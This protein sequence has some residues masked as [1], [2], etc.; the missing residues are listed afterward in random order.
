MDCTCF[1]WLKRRS[2]R[3]VSAL[4][5]TN[6]QTTLSLETEPRFDH[7]LPNAPVSRLIIQTSD[8]GDSDISECSDI[9][10]EQR[11][12][13]ETEDTLAA[14]VSKHAEITVGHTDEPRTLAAVSPSGKKMESC[15]SSPQHSFAVRAAAGIREVSELALNMHKHTPPTPILRATSSFGNVA[16]RRHGT[17][18]ESSVSTAPSSPRRV[19]FDLHSPLPIDISIIVEHARAVSDQLPDKHSTNAAGY[20]S[21]VEAAMKHV[22]HLNTLQLFQM[23]TQLKSIVKR[24]KKRFEALFQRPP[25]PSEI[26]TEIDAAYSL[27]SGMAREMEMR[28]S[29]IEGI[30]RSNL[31]TSLTHSVAPHPAVHSRPTTAKQPSRTRSTRRKKAKALNRPSSV[32]SQRASNRNTTELVTCATAFLSDELD[33]SLV[34]LQQ[35]YDE[36]CDALAAWKHRF[37]LVHGREAT[38]R[39]MFVVKQL[40]TSL[41]HIRRILRPRRA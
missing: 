6:P 34:E 17:G 27:Y 26:P 41:K 29:G 39:D 11:I 15:E 35:L 10:L 1:A 14:R 5:E 18:T 20:T 38:K 33:L 40:A 12:S 32:A 4:P 7:S 36:L 30:R 8:V 24:Y 21:N 19:S 22:P 31:H 9:E 16:E 28:S 37:L 23:K 3:R 13:T 25:W 2:E